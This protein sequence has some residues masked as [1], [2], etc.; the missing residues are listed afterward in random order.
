VE[1]R[2]QRNRGRLDKT[3]PWAVLP[4]ESGSKAQLVKV[5]ARAPSSGAVAVRSSEPLIPLAI[6]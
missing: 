1:F 3:D 5:I 2:K 4:A 6:Q